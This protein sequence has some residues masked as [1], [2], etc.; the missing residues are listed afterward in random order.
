MFKSLISKITIFL[1]TIIYV[2]FFYFLNRYNILPLRYRFILLGIILFIIL[3]FSLLIFR[4]KIKDKPLKAFFI[5]LLFLISAVEALF[6][7][8]ASTS[9]QTV[10]KI[11]QKKSDN[12]IKMSLVVLR[13]SPLETLNDLEDVQVA[14]AKNMDSKNINQALKKYKKE[15]GED[16]NVEDYGDYLNLGQSLLNGNTQAILL[17]ENFRQ[18]LDETLGEFSKQ[19]RVIKSFSVKGDDKFNEN[20]EV[21]KGESFNVYISG[22]DTYGDLSTVSRSDVNLIVSVNPKEGKI[23]ITTIPRDTYVNIAG[24]GDYANDKLTHAGL[25]GVDTS[26]KTLENFLD[27]NID[28]YAKVNF[29]TLTQLIDLLNGVDVENPVAFEANGGKYFPQGTIHMDGE[30]ALA[31]SRERYHL[32]E[33]DF[34]R[35]KNQVRVMTGIIR[36]LLSTETLLNFNSIAEV[37]LNSVNTNMPYDKMIEMANGQIDQPKNWKIKSQAVR[38][39]DA[40]GLPSYLMPGS[41]LYMMKADDESIDKIHDGILRNNKNKIEN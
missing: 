40:T 24:L 11:N 21:K 30:M 13:E 20:K 16:L 38:G 29:T 8:Y 31:Y 5:F 26:I 36:K 25:F 6:M 7:S 34:D 4:I 39:Q 18:M 28:Y 22:I 27:I 41:N 35:G 10:E 1:A 37:A 23:L 12:R 15:T 14:I 9:I 19:T 3:I 32:A 17:N 2:V 33:G